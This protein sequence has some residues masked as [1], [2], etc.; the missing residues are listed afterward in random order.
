MTKPEKPDRAAY[1]RHVQRMIL[2]AN[3]L[4]DDRRSE[5]TLYGAIAVLLA[6]V[7]VAIIWEV[8]HL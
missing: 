5:R 6:L 1:T 3:A 7:A 4:S 8:L 2:N